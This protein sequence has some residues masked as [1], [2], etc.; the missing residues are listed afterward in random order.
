MIGGNGFNSPAII[1][2][3]GEDAEGVV[4]G[5]AWNTAADDPLNEEFKAAYEERTGRQPDQFAAQSYAGV[6]LLAQ[7]IEDAGSGEPPAIRDALAELRDV[8]TVLGTFSF[9]DARDADHEGV[10]Q[11]IQD[12]EFR[13]LAD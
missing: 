1:E 4:V 5:A 10:T 11:I 2:Q 3:A 12:G 8:E 9:T 7:A 13:I 6:Y